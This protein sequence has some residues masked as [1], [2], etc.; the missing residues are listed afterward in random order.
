M[1]TNDSKKNLLWIK[2][3]ATIVTML[4]NLLAHEQSAGESFHDPA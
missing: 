3:N 4:F 1:H 2:V